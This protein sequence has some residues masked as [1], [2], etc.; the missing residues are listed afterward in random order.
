MTRQEYNKK[1]YQANKKRINKAQR[2]RIDNL[3][4]E[5]KLE[6]KRKRMAIA[7]NWRAKNLRNK[8]KLE[9]KEMEKYFERRVL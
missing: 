9:S 7:A 5:D 8:N 6:Y 1:Y 4:E 2:D 3:S